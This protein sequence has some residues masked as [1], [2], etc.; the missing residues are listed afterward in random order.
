MPAAALTRLPLFERLGPDEPTSPLVCAVPHAGRYYPPTLVAASAVPLHLLEQLEDRHAD[1]L[2]EGAVERGAVAIVARIARACIDLNRGEED[3]HPALRDPP[4]SG[5]AASARAR[6]GLGLLP[7][8][9]GKR[10]LWQVLPSPA[11][12]SARLELIHEP[13]PAAIADALAAASARF[14]CAVLIDCH[15]MPPLPGTRAARVVIGDKHGRSAGKGVAADM[16]RI[17]RALG[18][19]TALNAPYA[20]AYGLV[21]HGRPADN[22][23]ALQIEIDRT[24]YL[25]RDMRSLSP[26]LADAQ[27]LVASLAAAALNAIQSPSAIAAE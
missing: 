15:S 9:L 26:G 2:I 19:P 10:H 17:A 16:A 3:L 8:R 27:K 18:Y 21:R 11:A 22:V 23:H 1:L 7:D 14:G 24:L 6:S 5:G 20:G 4:G 25:E 13:Y 12:A